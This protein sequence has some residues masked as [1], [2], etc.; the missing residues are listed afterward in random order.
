MRQF[1]LVGLVVSLLLGGDTTFETREGV[2]ARR[3]TEDR[4][5]QG[6]V[7]GELAL[8]SGGEHQTTT[9]LSLMLV[10]PAVR[11]LVSASSPQ[12]DRS[13]SPSARAGDLA[14]TALSLATIKST[15]FVPLSAACLD[16]G[17]GRQ[18][19]CAP[20]AHP[21]VFP[22]A[23]GRRFVALADSAPVGAASGAFLSP[24]SDLLSLAFLA[25]VRL[26]G[27]SLGVVHLDTS[28]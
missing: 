8:I 6:A 5:L 12:G 24:V 19:V 27:R 2:S 9:A 1:A 20:S 15:S 18:L 3:S 23:L 22:P 13:L 11:R 7:S 4:A 16:D 28:V 26:H 14:A 21:I 17:Q 25:P 10:N